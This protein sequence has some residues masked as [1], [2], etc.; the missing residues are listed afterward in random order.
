MV[1]D[2]G[3]WKWENLSFELPSSTIS[4]ILGVLVDKD[5]QKEDIPVWQYNSKGMVDVKTAYFFI[6]GCLDGEKDNLRLKGI[7]VQNNCPICSSHPETL[8]QL[9]KNC[10]VTKQ[11]WNSVRG[12][13][14][15][16]TLWSIWLARNRL[17]FDKKVFTHNT[18]ASSALAKASE[19]YH[20]QPKNKVDKRM[21][22]LSIRWN[23]PPS[24]W[25]KINSDNSYDPE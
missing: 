12:I 13:V 4:S 18:V 25:V 23:P 17:V 8:E 9:F 14:F 10:V 24:G 19:F 22:T 2:V 11:V 7:N 15:T 5:S 21:I 1:K 20:L 16:Y 3:C 6:M